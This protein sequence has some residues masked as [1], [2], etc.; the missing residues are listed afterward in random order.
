ML[1]LTLLQVARIKDGL[2]GPL[3]DSDLDEKRKRFHRSVEALDEQ[4]NYLHL[5]SSVTANASIEAMS[6]RVK[7]TEGMVIRTNELAESIDNRTKVLNSHAGGI[8]TGLQRLRANVV[9]QYD[10]TRSMESRLQVNTRA[11]DH[12]SSILQD[13]L[14]YAECK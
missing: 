14:E 2:K 12:L 7:N 13:V 4:V 9:S 6:P 3:S 8:M 1:S 10:V 11:I 5:S